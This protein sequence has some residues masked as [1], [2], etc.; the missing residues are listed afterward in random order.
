MK[1]HQI[2]LVGVCAATLL[3]IGALTPTVAN[4]AHATDNGIETLALVNT[5]NNLKPAVNMTVKKLTEQGGLVDA[6]KA[7]AADPAAPGVAAP[8]NIVAGNGGSVPVSTIDTDVTDNAWK[9]L[10]NQPSNTDAAAAAICMNLGLK[11]VNITNGVFDAVNPAPG[12]PDTTTIQGI[13]VKS[14]LN[15]N[16]LESYKVGDKITVSFVSLDNSMNEI[17]TVAQTTITI[18]AE[19]ADYDATASNITAAVGDKYEIQDGLVVTDKATG[20]AL[21]YISPDALAAATVATNGDLTLGNTLYKQGTWYLAVDVTTNSDGDAQDPFSNPTAT[22]DSEQR[23][24]EKTNTNTGDTYFEYKKSVKFDQTVQIVIPNDNTITS[25]TDGTPITTGADDTV[26]YLNRTINVVDDKEVQPVPLY[27]AYNS[28]DGDHLFTTSNS[29][30]LN[31][32]SA[33]WAAEGIAWNAASSTAD[34]GY[35][36]YRLYNSN[37][38]EHFYTASKAE[39]MNLGAA[40]W[41]Q[42]GVGFNSPKAAGNVAVYRAF[43]PNAKGPGSHMFTT[44]KSEYDNIVKAG[45]TPEGIAFY[46][47]AEK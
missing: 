1:K 45:W 17:G 29:E 10:F 42:E 14:T 21:T 30:Y 24:E 36:V 22:P 40:G 38:G 3:T 35:V 28:N 31:V 7:A 25:V 19:D 47:L 15:V 5:N 26:F 43:N 2:K 39:Y 12:F 20:K 44:S 11:N 23:T 6:L 33:G 27:R 34:G 4:V 18:V 32:T 16:N 8:T 46:G 41:T 13:A 9:D 37:S